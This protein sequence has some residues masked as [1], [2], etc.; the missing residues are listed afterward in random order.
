MTTATNM[1][2]VNSV[3]LSG[4]TRAGQHLV[5]HG[6][7]NASG[8]ST[9]DMAVKIGSI[10]KSNLQ[11]LGAYVTCVSFY[12]GG[13]SKAS[14]SNIGGRLRSSSMVTIADPYVIIRKDEKYPEY[15]KNLIKG[16]VIPDIVVVD[17]DN[18][19]DVLKIAAKYT[20][21]DALLTSIEANPEDVNELKIS[22]RPH[23]VEITY[24]AWKPDGK[25]DGNTSVSFNIETGKVT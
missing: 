17:L 9:P 2:S 13:L 21:K 24:T 3:N 25:A 5:G 22:F 10:T 18:M 14:T 16:V 20:F 15:C 6:P 23:I 4:Q 12:D 19:G 7:T 8:V 11:G 1:G